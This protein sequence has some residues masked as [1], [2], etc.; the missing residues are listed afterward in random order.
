MNSAPKFDTE[1]QNRTSASG[2][3]LVVEITPEQLRSMGR[4]EILS[5]QEHLMMGS[6]WLVFEVAPEHIR[7]GHV[8][9]SQRSYRIELA[10]R[11][12]LDR[13]GEFAERVWCELMRVAIGLRMFPTASAKAKRPSFSYIISVL[14]KC[15][16][17]TRRMKPNLGGGFWSTVDERWD[18]RP[19]SDTSEAILRRLHILGALSD[20]LPGNPMIR[21]EAGPRHRLGES[22]VVKPQASVRQFLPLPDPFL[23][24]AGFAAI[25]FSTQ[26]GPTLLAAIEAAS[27]IALPHVA[28]NNPN[29][30]ISK[31]LTSGGKRHHLTPARDDVI[32]HWQWRDSTGE[33]LMELPMDTEFV[34]KW[35]KSGSR[36]GGAFEWPPKTFSEAIT[37]LVLL[38]GCHL[39]IIAL[40]TAGRHGEVQAM[41]VDSLR[42]EFSEVATTELPRWKI[43]GLGQSAKELPIPKLVVEVI[44]QQERLAE[45]AKRAGRVEGNHLWVQVTSR[46]GAALGSFNHSLKNFAKKFCLEDA[47]DDDGIHMHRFRKTLVRAVALSLVHA[48]K[49]LM[50]LLGHDDEQMTIMRYILSDPGILD[51]IREMVREMMIL[52]GVDVI[53]RRDE[54]EGAGAAAMKERIHEYSRRLG[55]SA[56][57]PQNV[58][59]FASAMTESGQGWAIIAPGVICTGFTKG[60]LCNKGQRG[61]ANPHH[62]SPSCHNQIALSTFERGGGEVESALDLAIASV[63]YLFARLQEAVDVGEEML[64]A[65]FSGQIRSLTGRWSAVDKH[66]NDHPLS[67][68]LLQ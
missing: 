29:R 21:G 59:E 58:R 24:R 13:H 45:F 32:L 10:L 17:R 4:R 5:L 33:N 8:T 3:A 57:E 6:E 61:G 25:F 12:D 1:S 26:V 36:E 43:G 39:W 50:D 68:L 65:Q 54:L 56:F 23:G 28:R 44:K 62:C 37:L 20:C 53:L 49:V 55:Q 31:N 30:S 7:P 19:I 38:Q 41:E 42:R 40:A 18:S 64:V 51:E 60:G 11:E 47:L 67:I 66:T 52:K 48:P 14:R 27:E 15:G 22:D 16:M 35:K 9:L 2:A 34:S 46:R 63:D